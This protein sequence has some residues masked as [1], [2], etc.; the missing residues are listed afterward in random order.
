MLED[1]AL[2]GALADYQPYY[3]AKADLLDRLGDTTGAVDCLEK[4][5]ALSDNE[6]DR[7]FLR[8]KAAQLKG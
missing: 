4:A 1:A 6:A 2:G 5:I 3:A 7:Q 8:A